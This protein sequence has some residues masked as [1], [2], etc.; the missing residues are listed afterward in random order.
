[1]IDLHTHT[2][3]SDGSYTPSDL[4]RHAAASGIT[5]LAITDHDTVAGIAEAI[6]AAAALEKPAIEAASPMPGAPSDQDIARTKDAPR[7]PASDFTAPAS[8]FTAPASPQVPHIRIIPA[9][10]CS[11]PGIRIIPGVELDI[12]WKP[13]ECHLL[14]LGLKTFHPDLLA[15]L[16]ALIADRN[17]RNAEI[18]DKLRASGIDIDLARVEALANGGTV[19]RPHFAQYLTEA[20]VVKNRQQAFDKYLAK[21][22]PFYIDRNS[23]PLDAGIAAIRACGG[24]PVLAHPMSLYVSWGTLPEVL[25]GFVEQGVAGFEAWHPGAR[26]NDCKRLEALAREFGVC[27]TAG[28]DF[29][30]AV[31]PDR[32]IG[33][34]AGGTKIEDRYFFDDLLPL[35][36]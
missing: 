11:T 2:R 28:S 23:I 20:K 7:G 4:V 18:A 24:V 21:D 27:V 1:M 19:G 15:L 8:D 32:K 3:A 17:R 31:R 22:R 34:T 25:K 13:G 9:V 14:G 36:G 30:G 29:H 10:N 26:V 12:D 16:D 6:E 5:V 33:H 35:L